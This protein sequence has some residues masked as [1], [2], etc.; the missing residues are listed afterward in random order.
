MRSIL[1][2]KKHH[3]V[4]NRHVR[5]QPDRVLRSHP[6]RGLNRLCDISDW[7]QG[8]FLEILQELREAPFIH[9]KAWEYGVCIEGM[10]RLGLV[11]PD[12]SALA[13][14]AGYERPLFYYANRL[15][16]MVATDIY[17]GGAEGRPEML[18]DPG[19]FAPFEF[20]R[21]RLEVHQMDGCDLE[22]DDGTFDFV[23]CLSSIEHFGSR[24]RIVDAMREMAR[25]VKVGGAVCIITEYILNDATHPEYFTHDE[26]QEYIIRSTSLQLA[27]PELD[28]SIS[29]SLLN[30]PIDLDSETDLHVAP[31]IVLAQAGVI[32]T[33]LSLFFQKPVP[34]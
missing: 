13:V 23:F 14:G 17:E 32:W 3:P 29:E 30:H 1:A 16:R 12:C 34:G 8:R 18:T 26:L 5:V 20:R 22:F 9:R 33:S 10:E 4:A 27:E 11:R 24:K 15:A 2:R 25:V 21:D 7:R 31:H 6:R 28:L 19:Q